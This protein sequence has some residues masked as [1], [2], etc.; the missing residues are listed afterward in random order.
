MND[1]DFPVVI[2][3]DRYGGVYSGGKWL[4]IAEATRMEN[5]AYRVVRCLEDGPYGEDTD[6]MVFWSDPPSWVASGNTPEEAV[7]KLQNRTNFK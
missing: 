4:A 2:V 7:A 3:Q 1:Q 5:G 6:A